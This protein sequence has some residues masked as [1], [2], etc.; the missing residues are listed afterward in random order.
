VISVDGIDWLVF[1][2]YDA[3]DKGR[4]KLRMEKIT[5]VDGWPVIRRN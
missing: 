2:A 1:H 3:A 5:W 4:S